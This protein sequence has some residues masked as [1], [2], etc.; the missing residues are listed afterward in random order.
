MGA[1]EEQPVLKESADALK[2][3]SMLMQSQSEGGGLLSSAHDRL[4]GGRCILHAS[5]MTRH[6]L[7]HWNT[8]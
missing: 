8:D 6:T 1:A 4:R 7:E 2:S 5:R 3:P